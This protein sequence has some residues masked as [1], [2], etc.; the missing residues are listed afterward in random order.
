MVIKVLGDLY[1]IVLFPLL[2]SERE[3]G[4]PGKGLPVIGDHKEAE[5]VGGGPLVELAR[6]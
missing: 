2:I 6:L 4:V 1:R 3:P 5:L